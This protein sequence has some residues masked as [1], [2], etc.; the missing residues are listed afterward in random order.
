MDGFCAAWIARRMFPNAKF[1]AVQYDDGGFP[2]VEHGATVYILDFS[3]KPDIIRDLAERSQKVTVLDH[4]KTAEQNL[5]PLM[6]KVNNLII[7]FDMNKSGGR[8]AWEHFYPANNPHWL[9][10]YT[11]DHDLWRHRLPN[12]KEIA[13]YIYSW[14]LD[15]EIW[16]NWSRFPHPPQEWVNEGAAILRK[17][18]LIVNNHVAQA[19]EI[20]MGGHRILAVNATVL[21]SDIA[22]KLAEDRPFGA[23]YFEKANGRRQW[24]LRSRDGGIDVSV[25]AKA[26]GGGGHKNASG[27][28]ESIDTNPWRA[29]T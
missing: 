24:A 28:E 29:R 22:G 21:F 3:Y 14:P 26:Y 13:A 20:E 18:R 16:D 1:V 25:I 15:F 9:V 2:Q 6:G 27:F 4:H 11:E 19:R 8:L 7:R 10:D 12:T 5:N 17:E 23:C